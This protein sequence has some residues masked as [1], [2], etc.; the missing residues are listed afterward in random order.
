MERKGDWQQTYTGGQFW[1]LDP[2]PGDFDVRDI[3]H[4]LAL[5]C[6]FAGHCRVPYSV[7][8]H[9]VRAARWVQDETNGD[10]VLTL[11][12][13]MHDAS[14]AY[15]VDVPRPLKRW[16][17]GYREIEGRVM[18]AI[19]TWAGLP[20]GACSCD[21]VHRADE[22]MLMTEARD[23][24]GPSPAPWTFAQGV[25]CAPLVDVIEPWPWVRAE[26]EF[27]YLFRTLQGAR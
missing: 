8:E 24:L 19:E 21:P 6:R 17:S 1:P 5:Q 27:L 22:I 26:R 3:A 25:Q 15:C 23:L 18:S 7:A 4:S 12:A 2:R 16:L 13:L 14:E 20:D 10:T 11:A 9:S